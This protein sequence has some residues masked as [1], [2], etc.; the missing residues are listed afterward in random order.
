MVALICIIGYLLIGSVYL[1][2]F[3]EYTNWKKYLFAALWPIAFF[4]LGA[5][6]LVKAASPNNDRFHLENM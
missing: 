5:A 1:F 4:V 6:L 2:I 3:G